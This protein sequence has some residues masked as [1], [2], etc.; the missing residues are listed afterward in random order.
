MGVEVRM[1]EENIPDRGTAC[2]NVWEEKEHGYFRVSMDNGQGKEAGEAE[3]E[4]R[5]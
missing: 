3:E 1:G 4:Q 2:V 5:P